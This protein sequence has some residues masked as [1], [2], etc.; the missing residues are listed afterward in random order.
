MS[1]KLLNVR[2][3]LLVLERQFSGYEHW[4]FLQRTWVQF[5]VP[6]WCLRVCNSIQ[7]DPAPPSGL[8]WQ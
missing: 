4:L 6:T 7:K 1:V 5:P 8:W 2:F 3:V